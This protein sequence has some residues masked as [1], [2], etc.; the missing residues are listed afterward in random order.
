M[1]FVWMG[2]RVGGW[3]GAG[4]GGGGL[5][6]GCDCVL[7]K[8]GG[9]TPLALHLFASAPLVSPSAFPMLANQQAIGSK[10]WFCRPVVMPMPFQTP[11][12]V[13]THGLTTSA[14]RR[15]PAEAHRMAT[16]VIEIAKKRGGLVLPP[17]LVAELESVIA[18][19]GVQAQATAA[20][21]AALTTEASASSTERPTPL[22]VKQELPTPQ[23]SPAKP[24]QPRAGSPATPRTPGS[25]KAEPAEK[26]ATSD[27]SKS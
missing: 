5:R 18:S 1:G 23:A 13:G 20:Q 4:G 11:P 22:E 27:G 24:P 14:R 6:G 8:V 15:K 3:V 12:Y 21:P 9:A 25:V 19:A 17:A 16:E 2:A 10:S 7:A 26:V